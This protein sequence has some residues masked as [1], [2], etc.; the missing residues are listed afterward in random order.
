MKDFN[1]PQSFECK[2]TVC[3]PGIKL[4]QAVQSWPVFGSIVFATSSEVAIIVI[5]EVAS[6]FVESYNRVP[7]QVDTDQQMNTRQSD[8]LL[9]LLRDQIDSNIDTTE[10]CIAAKSKRRLENRGKAKVSSRVSA[11]ASPQLNR[12]RRTAAFPRT[13]VRASKW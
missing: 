9:L 10:K 4:T 11:A 12:H 1:V 3:S 5:V 7:I 2:G 8:W 6:R 13:G